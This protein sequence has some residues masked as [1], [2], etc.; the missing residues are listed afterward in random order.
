MSNFEETDCPNCGQRI[1][2]G[3]YRYERHCPECG[4]D[5]DDWEQ[6]EERIYNRARELGIRTIGRSLEEIADEVA[7]RDATVG[8]Q[9]IQPTQPQTKEIYRERETI[10][11]VVKI[12]CRHCGRLHEEKLDTCPHCGAPS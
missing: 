10:R 3:A 12:R 8:N 1:N 2:Y 9:I 4:V 11:E 5:F 6:E 7:K